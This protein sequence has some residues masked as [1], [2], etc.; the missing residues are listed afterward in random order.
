M[1]VLAADV[2]GRYTVFLGLTDVNLRRLQDAQPMR[3]PLDTPRQPDDVVIF[4]ATRSALLELADT[5]GVPQTEFL[6]QVGEG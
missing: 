1:I 6:D 2:G 4:H 5:L 3:R